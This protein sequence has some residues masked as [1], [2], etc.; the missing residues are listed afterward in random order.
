MF[1]SAEKTKM[2]TFDA[3]TQKR[4]ATLVSLAMEANGDWI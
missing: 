1:D 2:D 4:R 3:F